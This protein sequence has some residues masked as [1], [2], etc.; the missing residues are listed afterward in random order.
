VLGEEGCPLEPVLRILNQF[1]E[2]DHQT[3]WE[4]PMYMQPLK[5]NLTD[6]LL[7]QRVHLLR[8]LEQPQQY[9]TELVRMTVR[10]A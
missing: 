7:N 2:I 3:P 6:L 10:I 5:Q 1:A 9:L 4:R 8:L